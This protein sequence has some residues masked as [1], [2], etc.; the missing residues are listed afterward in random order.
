MH[1]PH[2]LC[3]T[4]VSV[5]HVTA[6]SLLCHGSLTQSSH[7]LATLP[8]HRPFD[9][10]GELLALLRLVV[11]CE[12]RREVEH[13]PLRH[14]T[15]DELQAESACDDIVATPPLWP[16][17]PGIARI[18]THRRNVLVLVPDLTKTPGNTKDIQEPSD[19]LLEDSPQILIPDPGELPRAIAHEDRSGLAM[20]L[21]RGWGRE[22]EDGRSGE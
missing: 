21:G 4:P 14:A 7:S 6:T 13:P 22:V 17:G 2:S 11:L 1:R 9:D 10:V 19:F 18:R 5:R 3:F 16:L 12:D 8:S 20:A 15:L